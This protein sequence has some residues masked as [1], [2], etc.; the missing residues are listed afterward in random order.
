MQ[1]RLCIN[2]I[3]LAFEATNCCSKKTIVYFWVMVMWK[4]TV[5]KFSF[6][7]SSISESNGITLFAVTYFRDKTNEDKLI[8][9]LERF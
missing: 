8:Y 7:A 6:K 9:N 2:N 1:L 5:N 4:F 3:M